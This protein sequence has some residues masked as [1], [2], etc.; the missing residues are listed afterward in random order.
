MNTPERPEDNVDPEGLLD[1][2]GI[3]YRRTHGRSGEQLNVRE[4]PRCRGSGWKVYLNAESGL[5]NCF[6]GS[7]AGEKGFSLFSFVRH[8]VGDAKEANRVISAYAR[9]LGW[10]PKRRQKP[11]AEAPETDH[12]EPRLPPSIALPDAN[13]QIHVY[14]AERG[15]TA[16][17]CAHFGWRYCHQGK[18]EIPGEPEERW[19]NYSQ[20]ILIPVRDLEGRLV[21]FQ[22]RD[23]TGQSSRKYLFPPGLPGTGRFFYNGQEAV[24]CEELIIGEGAF[25]VAAIRQ[26]LRGDIT[27]ASIGVVGSFGKSLSLGGRDDQK[28]ELLK[29]KAAGLKSITLMWDGER[30]TTIDAI[31][32]ARALH[33]IGFEANVALLP[34]DK[35]PN[36]VSRETIVEAYLH[37]HRI[38]YSSAARLIA[39]VQTG[40]L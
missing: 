38:D 34:K 6:H 8:H 25:D 35:D 9:Q 30:R 11:A 20:R 7:C 13:G 24:G 2:L 10:R 40:R 5:G 37:A 19:Q 16:D 28:T 27:M 18:Y 4:C 17:D 3:S 1:H 21:N 31:K 23:I 32:V 29:L 22:G 15:F 36:E 14:L 33:G 26:A 39:L 12:V